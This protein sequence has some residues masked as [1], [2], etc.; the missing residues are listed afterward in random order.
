MRR[1]KFFLYL[2]IL[3]FT[4]TMFPGCP[5]DLETGGVADLGNLDGP[6]TVLMNGPIRYYS[7][8]TGQETLSPASQDWD[9][10]FDYNR[11]IYT[12]SGDTADLLGS[13]GQGG[14]WCTGST[15][16]AA[17]NSTSGADFT[18]SFARDTKRFTNPAA[19]MGDPTENRINVMTY[20]GYGS[21]NGDSASTPLTDYNYSAQQFYNANLSEMPPIYSTTQRVYIIRHGNGTEYSKVQITSMGTI[22]SAKDGNRRIYQ[23]NYALLP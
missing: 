11:L 16:F 5:T 14:V 19:D 1:I 15:N 6:V 22:N 7:L 13:G 9:I 3:V 12:N 21:G 18:V 8:A 20:I 17:V 2:A 4:G 10:A 23:I